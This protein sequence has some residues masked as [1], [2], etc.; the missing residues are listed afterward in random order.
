MANQ[1]RSNIPLAYSNIFIH[2]WVETEQGD[3][4]LREYTKLFDIKTSERAFEQ[5][6]IFTGFDAAPE[7]P[8]GSAYNYDSS[9]QGTVTTYRIFTYASGYQVSQEAQEDGYGRELISKMTPLLKRSLMIT[10]NQIGANVLNEG[11]TT[12]S[13]NPTG[14]GVPLFSTSHPT[15]AGLQSNILTTPADLSYSS[16]LDLITQAMN[17]KS[18]RNNPTPLTPEMLVVPVQLWNTGTTILQTAGAPGVAN[19]D[20]NAIQ[21][22]GNLFPKGMCVNHYL[23]DPDAWFI[24]TDAVDGMVMYERI[25]IAIQ[26]VDS[27]VSVAGDI[28]VRGRWRGAANVTNFRGIFGTQGAA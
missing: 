15:R 18:D 4:Q 5:E 20:V 3:D 28:Q 7:K 1:V 11:F 21:A 26:P 6:V 16:L 24:K 17:A 22:Y 2:D 13:I 14:D 19:N 8:E 23:T 12:N 9:T 25:P 10:I 27:T